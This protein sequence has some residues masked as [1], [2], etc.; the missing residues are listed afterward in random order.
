LD[1]ETIVAVD[2]RAVLARLLR[3]ARPYYPRLLL[4]LGLGVIAGLGPLSYTEAVNLVIQHVLAP[5]QPDWRILWF[6]VIGLF[7]VGAISNAASY[8]QNYLTAWSGQRLIANLRV[9]LFSRVMRLPLGE[10]DRWRP[11]EF[12]ARFTNDL[13]LMTDAISISLPQLIQTII[14]LLGALVILFY[15]DWLLTLFLVAFAPA[16]NWVVAFFTRLISANTKRAQ[17]RIADLAA[18]L[19]ET[20]QG[21]RIVKAFG[22]EAFET[23][24][25]RGSNERY[26]GAYMKLTQLGQT[27]T[28]VVAMIM[29]LALLT[30]IVFSVREKSVGN[31]NGGELGQ[32]Y[33]ALI[34]ASNPINRFASFIGDLTKGLVGASRVY[35]ILDLPVE[36]DDG[37]AAV[38]L[39]A[40]RGAIAYED[41]TF[42]YAP[43]T[44]PI[45][46]DLNLDIPAG[47]IV[48]F[49][50]PSG[51]GKT[52]IVNLVP[53]FYAPQRGRVTLDGVDTAR[54]SLA[55]L[56]EAIAIVPQ[57]PLLFSGTVGEN[58]RYGRLDATQAEIEDAAREANAEEFILDLPL[59]YD[60]P[61]GDRGIRLSGGQRQRIAIARAVLRDPRI[62]IL[63]E[64]T[65]A[66]DSHSE[67]LIESALDRL[68]PGRT[69]LIIAHRLSTIRRAS[70]IF[71]VEAGRIVER[72]N[73]DEL[74]ALGGAYARLS[75]AQFAAG[76]PSGP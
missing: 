55:Q 38:R 57:E 65:S 35:E 11:G 70:V 53:R 50:G 7:A 15:R 34:L 44:A 28:P 40:I 72:G 29:M 3:E 25:F 26:F 61:V 75:A 1:T 14:T 60:T 62:L 59:G 10:F 39:P 22:R 68:L 23:E 24:R 4:A 5:P 17:E 42:A 67:R 16:V 48:A 52:T 33:L 31:M 76:A 19:A 45:L 6:V 69:T 54:C 47:E 12:L 30:I 51:A 49:V 73:H 21:E 46:V 56:R 71:Y 20:L 41:V 66:L 36:T 32:Y 74:L 13:S 8:G 2:R 9:A 58:V 43:G 64:A 37:P 27:Q 18:N 63:D